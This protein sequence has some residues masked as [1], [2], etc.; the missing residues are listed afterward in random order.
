ML[1]AAETR[2]V[3]PRMGPGTEEDVS[4]KTNK[5]ATFILSTLVN[6]IV[7]RLIS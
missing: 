7:S 6:A 2:Q 3:N 1:G 5:I 4:E